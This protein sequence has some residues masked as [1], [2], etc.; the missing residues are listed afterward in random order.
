MGSARPGVDALRQVVPQPLRAPMLVHVQIGSHGAEVTA[1]VSDGQ[2]LGRRAFSQTHP[3]LVGYLARLLGTA[4]A[5]AQKAHD[6]F[7]V[8]GKFVQEVRRGHGRQA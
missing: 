5:A 1:R 7:I 2:G 3:G 6:G 4:Q 8:Q